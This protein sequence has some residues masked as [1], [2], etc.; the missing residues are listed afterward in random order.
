MEIVQQQF[1]EMIIDIKH[2][3][4]QYARKN[5]M[6]MK[7]LPQTPNILNNSNSDKL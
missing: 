3:N 5:K 6:N 1:C 7:L 2:T 4:Q